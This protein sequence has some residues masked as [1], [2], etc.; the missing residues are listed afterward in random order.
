MYLPF[1]DQYKPPRVSIY[2]KIRRLIEQKIAQ[3]DE[4]KPAVIYEELISRMMPNRS[5]TDVG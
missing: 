5:T 4:R 2:L 1:E 3:G